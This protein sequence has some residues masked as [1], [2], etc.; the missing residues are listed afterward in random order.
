M[1][2]RVKDGFIILLPVADLVRIFGEIL[3]I[4][5]SAAVSHSQRRL[6]IILNISAQPDTGT[7]SV[8]YTIDREIAPYSMQFEC[9]F[10]CILQ[11][12]WEADPVKGL[13]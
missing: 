11:A 5:C 2:Q 9:V 4:F 12:I 3:K 1:Q 10:P 7:P 8:N 13:V 6:H